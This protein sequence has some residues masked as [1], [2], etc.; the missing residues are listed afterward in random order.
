MSWIYAWDREQNTNWYNKFVSY[1]DW[2]N[3]FNK[4]GLDK[5]ADNSVLPLFGFT[6]RFTFEH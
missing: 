4:A 1:I 2:S 3:K 5:L 6:R